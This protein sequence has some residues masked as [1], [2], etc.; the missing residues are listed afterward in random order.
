MASFYPEKTLNNLTRESD[1]ASDSLAEWLAKT[2]INDEIYLGWLKQFDIKKYETYRKY[3][4]SL[5]IETN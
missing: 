4:K 3:F 1:I 2:R 5:L